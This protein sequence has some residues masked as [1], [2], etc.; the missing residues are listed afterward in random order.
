MNQFFISV[1]ISAL[2]ILVIQILA[3]TQTA[4]KPYVYFITGLVT[5]LIV[6]GPLISV[7]KELAGGF[8]ISLPE[9]PQYSVDSDHRVLLADAEKSLSYKIQAMIEE[10]YAASV[11]D[12][13]VSLQYDEK[14]KIFYI[15]NIT[16]TLENEAMIR[17]I[18]IYL[19][20]Q[21]SCEI[22][23]EGDNYSG[24]KVDHGP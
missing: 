19:E 22:T 3:E 23:V 16:V 6:F 21:F 24:E 4:T 20:N 2:I 9:T 12:V 15:Q 10:K 18:E 11:T 7:V 13:N 5:I 17:E 8:S 14:R 1:F